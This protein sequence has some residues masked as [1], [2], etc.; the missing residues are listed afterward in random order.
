MNIDIPIDIETWKANIPS[1]FSLASTVWIYQSNKPFTEE[2]QQAIQK[3]IDAFTSSW[4][5]HKQPV[6][7]W[8]TLLFNRFIILMADETLVQV[9]GCSK[10]S[11]MHCIQSIQKKY[12]VDLL[13][14][15]QLA[16][17]TNNAIEIIPIDILAQ[18]IASAAIDGQT[19]Y[20]NNTINNKHQLLHEWIVETQN[21]WLKQKYPALHSR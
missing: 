21:S 14:R 18:K 17:I 12:T 15:T 19:L 3:T 1:N 7:A 5:S 8:G 16:F 4:L 10:D 20:F 13:N 2:E 9:S 11:M 6:T